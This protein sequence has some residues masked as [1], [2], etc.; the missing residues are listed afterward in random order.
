MLNQAFLSRTLDFA[1]T[2]TREAGEMAMKHFRHSKRVEYKADRSPVTLADREIEQFLRSEI[3]RQFPEHQILGE[4][5]DAKTSASDYT[6]ILDPIDGTRSFAHGIP[7]F[8]IQMALVYKK[9]PVVGVIHLPALGEHIAAARGLGC[10]WNEETCRVSAQQQVERL[11]VHV[12]ERE[13]SR[14]TAPKLSPWLAQTENERNWGD[15]YS[16]ILVAT[17]RAEVAMDP[18]MQVWDTAPLPVLVEEAG[19]VF[20]DWQGENS[21]WTGS[22]VTTTPE[23]APTLLTLLEKI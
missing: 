12:H 21:I 8:G 3:E 7:V 23:L 16:F 10:R 9:K 11:L 1:N 14:Q 4:E 2:L 15:C 22:A 13:L 17:G 5:F 6:W 19:G 18:R 20:F